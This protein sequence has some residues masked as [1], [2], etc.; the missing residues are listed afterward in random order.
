VTGASGFI[1]RYL[2]RHLHL[3]GYRVIGTGRRK[4]VPADIQGLV[5][6]WISCDLGEDG[7]S[8]SLAEKAGEVH[9]LFHLA[10]TVRD[11]TDVFTLSRI[12]QS[13]LIAPVQLSDLLG[14]K[15]K[16]ICF[17]SSTAVYGASCFEVD[18]SIP[19]APSG[20]Y[21]VNKAIIEDSLGLVSR[22]HSVPF[23]IMRISSAYGPGMPLRN[24]IPTFLSCIRQGER[25][26]ILSDPKALRDYVYVE[27]VV[28]AAE[29]AARRRASGVYNIAS[30]SPVGLQDVVRI[31][32]E[33][34]GKQVEPEVTATPT[35][36]DQIVNTDK[37]RRELGFYPT[38]LAEGLQRMIEKTL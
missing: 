3:A 6:K 23:C 18:E 32:G 33:L 16:H 11:T 24:A 2:V 29:Y 21:G 17:F 5:W 27:D 38:P 34:S 15:L 36:T 14:K 9:R 20:L 10:A 8:Y 26:K 31:L 12:S 1:G 13:D 37:A 7:A 25:P 22:L 35:G 28:L 30:G 19:L 4:E